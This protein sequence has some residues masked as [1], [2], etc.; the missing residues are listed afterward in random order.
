MIVRMLELKEVGALLNSSK[1]VY[2]NLSES[3]VLWQH[4]ITQLN[5][6]GKAVCN[7]LK[8]KI[9]ILE[10]NDVRFSA[11]K[12]KQEGEKEITTLIDDY[13]CKQKTL[14][15]SIVKVVKDCK[16]FIYTGDIV[17]APKVTE[18]TPQ[19]SG[20]FFG[21]LSGMFSFGG[22]TTA[23]KEKEENPEK[24]LADIINNERTISPESIVTT[25]TN[26]G[27]RVAGT[28][29]ERMNKWIATLQKCFATLYKSMLYFYCE[30]NEVEQVMDFLRRRFEATKKEL[31]KVKNDIKQMNNAYKSCQEVSFL[32]SVG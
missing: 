11:L 5:L 17:E 2:V 21:A 15:G 6:K 23:K 1:R 12:V 14:G 3:K 13:I 9:E 31:T 10:D 16:S 27:R 25:L 20:G 19:T 30:A 8:K 18:E 29:Q 7:K 4:T 32:F 24:V 28:S 26:N 22:T